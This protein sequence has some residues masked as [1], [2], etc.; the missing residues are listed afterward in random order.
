ME[1]FLGF[2]GDSLGGGGLLDT[3]RLLERSFKYK[4]YISRVHVSDTRR[5]FQSGR[6]LNHSRFTKICAVSLIGVIIRDVR[7]IA[8]ERR[9]QSG[10]VYH[11]PKNSGNFGW[12]V[13]GSPK[14]KI[15]K[16]FG[17]SWKV[18]QYGQPENPNGKCAYH[19]LICWSSASNLTRGYSAQFQA[20]RVNSCKW[21]TPN[22][23]LKSHSVF[24][25]YQGFVQTVNQPVSPC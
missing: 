17:T 20:L 4:L 10:V 2:W 7:R 24:L 9:H 6:L 22:L 23:V 16:I 11:L 15:S 19:L 3:K 1:H 12:V 14:R 8:V 13:N 5:L 18:V 25:F 21:N